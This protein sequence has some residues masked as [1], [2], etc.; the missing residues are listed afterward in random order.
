M[1]LPVVMMVTGTAHKGNL[2]P[3]GGTMKGRE[4]FTP[5]PRKLPQR[6][7]CWGFWADTAQDTAHA[8]VPVLEAQGTAHRRTQEAEPARPWALWAGPC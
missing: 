4:I 5:L 6:P 3:H 7:W 1:H 2:S 8:T